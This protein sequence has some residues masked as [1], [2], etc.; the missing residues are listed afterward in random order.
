MR[1]KLTSIGLFMLLLFNVNFLKSQTIDTNAVDGQ[2]Y[3]KIFDHENKVF[4]L[5]DGTN[6][7]GLTEDIKFLIQKFG[8]ASIEKAFPD[9]T[10]NIKISKIY[11]I[12]FTHYN[13][14]YEL[15]SQFSGR[16]Y[17]EYSERVP[18]NKIFC[19][20][21][22]A[23]YPSYWTTQAQS[24]HLNLINACGAWGINTGN[25]GVNVAIVDNEF[26]VLHPDLTNIVQSW[27][28]ADNDNNVAGPNAGFD[29]GTHV[30]GIAGASTNNN[31][32]IASIG[33]N[34]S[35][36]VVKATSD[37]A[38][39]NSIT[40]GYQAITWAMNNG[41]D[42][43]NCSW[44]GT[45]YSAAE[46]TIIDQAINAGIVVVAAAGNDNNNTPH[47][48]AAYNGVYA[49]ANTDLN[50]VK[51][52]SSC[53]GNWVDISAPGTNI[54]SSVYTGG[55]G[56]KTG[57]SMASPLV[58]G[59]CGLI[60]SNNPNYTPQQVTNCISSTAELIGAQ[61]NPVYAGQL[62]TGRINALAAMQCSQT[63]SNFVA[64]SANQTTICANSPITFTDAS[65]TNSPITSW[66]WSFPGSLTPNS[67]SQNP[68]VIYPTG[69]EY[70]V[71]LTITTANGTFTQTY[72]TYVKVLGVII[73]NAVSNSPV[74][75]GAET[76]VNLI[77][78]GSPQYTV[79]YNV[80]NGTTLTSSLN[81]N[82]VPL[83]FNTSNTV[84]NTTLNIVSITANGVTCNSTESFTITTVNCCGELVTNGDFSAGNTSFTTDQILDCS[85][86]CPGEYCVGSYSGPAAVFSGWNIFPTIQDRG[87]SL[88]I[89]GRCNPNSC[90]GNLT[91]FNT[92]GNGN[93]TAQNFASILW[94][95]QATLTANTNYNVSFFTTQGNPPFA[96]NA[97]FAPLHLRFRI[98]DLTNTTIFTSTVFEV[99]STIQQSWQQ[100]YF[101][102][103]NPVTS[104]A[105]YNIIIEQVEF[106]AFGFYDFLMDDISMRVVNDPAASL[107][108]TSNPPSGCA[109]FPSTLNVS[110]SN[111]QESNYTYS[112]TIPPSTIPFSNISNP[113]VNPTV[114]TT[115]SLSVFEST[116]RCTATNT[117]TV[118][119]VPC[120][121]YCAD[122]AAQVIPEGATST[123]NPITNGTLVDIQGT[124]IINTN[125]TLN[126]VKFRMAA[127]SSII[128]NP[129]FTWSVSNSFFFSCTDMWKGI[130]ISNNSATFVCS[131][132]RIEDALS[133]INS[134]SGGKYNIS[135]ST[136]NKNYVGLFVDSYSST[137]S[138]TVK[139][140]LFDCQTSTTSPGAF[141]KSPYLGVRSHYGIDV[142]NNTSSITFGVAGGAGN[143]NEFT[144][145]DVGI[146]SSNSVM[147]SYNNYFHD[148][149]R[150]CVQT[151]GDDPCQYEGWGIVAETFGKLY[152]GDLSGTQTFSNNYSNTFRNCDGGILAKVQVS[153]IFIYKNNFENIG[154]ATIPYPNNK[155]IYVVSNYN[156]IEACLIQNNRF[157]DNYISVQYENNKYPTCR[158]NSNK[159]NNSA[160]YGIYCRQ[161]Y[162]PTTGTHNLEIKYNAMNDSTGASSI[163]GIVAQNSITTNSAR[164]TIEANSIKKIQRAIWVTKF[165]KPVVRFH[166]ANYTTVSG[167]SAGIT[168]PNVVPTAGNPNYGICVENSPSATIIENNVQKQ[169]GNPTTAYVG[170]SYGISSSYSPGSS[171]VNNTVYRMGT[172]LNFFGT[173]N[174]Q[175]AS[176]NLMYNNRVGLAQDNTF[177]GNQGSSTQAQDNQ[178]NIPGGTGWISA[179]NVPIGSS[180]PFFYSRSLS[181]PFMS[182]TTN[183]PMS[184]ANAIQPL[185]T[186]GSPAYS[187]TF[188][189]AS[190]PCINPNIARI[191]KRQAPFEALPLEEQ[192][193]ADFTALQLIKTYDSLT[194]PNE[195]EAPTLL[196]FK[197]SLATTNTG[198]LA[199]FAEKMDS[200]DSLAAKQAL[201]AVAPSYSPEENAKI[202][203]EIYYRTWAKDV[204][205]FNREDSTRLLLVAQQWPLKGGMAVYDARVMIGYWQNDFT[206]YN[207]DEKAARLMN[208]DEEL[209]NKDAFGVLYPNPAQNEVHYD[210]SLSEEETGMLMIYDA[211][212]KLVHAEKIIAGENKLLMNTE[213]WNNGVYLY[214]LLINDQPKASQT[215]IINK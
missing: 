121:Q 200:G 179:S 183:P 95:Q 186:S 153:N 6:T 94:A 102:V 113:T 141:L 124:Y 167:T 169:G 65:V 11:R 63:S 157:R 91:P 195:P 75:K 67:N 203:D 3:V 24:G 211:L 89:D 12:T 199:T 54:L 55:Y 60:L 37:A 27:D 181:L 209:E 126:N 71:T 62:G 191:A 8:I 159:F 190:P 215:F 119:I 2:I 61:N 135:G 9:I 196:A 173:N 48:P 69:G 170:L 97:P 145:I 189:C 29:H 147:K 35:L 163:Y 155:A 28:R 104:N 133:G 150:Y 78:T 152:V 31:T 174:A 146:H 34:I 204:F 41:A 194:M 73:Q 57:T 131:K 184:P 76:Q 30:A 43:I 26:N 58:A 108:I 132:N 96:G 212:G 208:S 128:I 83:Y 56:I 178:W 112:W 44:G 156:N 140:S 19:T 42:V 79:N 21:E 161:N 74:C 32:G 49:V 134:L 16:N 1:N 192:L 127:G 162:N 151:P 201:I 84:A 168:F 47:Y 5:Y 148:L 116:T 77:L 72:Q 197:D 139:S 23:T 80:D 36:I 100:V 166:S 175:T 138:S 177:I 136:F 158:I 22:G 105:T 180:S 7:N 66:A 50:D 154:S 172:G 123:T 25:N 198:L 120:G 114:T 164:L 38:A 101:N 176:C 39:G 52:P 46:Q 106:F 90:G 193:V 130:Y 51:S 92:P 93:V 82:F 4:P 10:N 59:L 213:Q 214:R 64:F 33:R 117:A 99:P 144:N 18:L 88:V 85:S 20:N 160:L 53:F 149:R 165:Q 115:Y 143:Q 188:G 118:T 205:F 109:G 171:V 40:H 110:P 81:H 17:V 45:L 15:M 202:V 206:P 86:G 210:I 87:Q 182:A 125:V 13:E 122:I 70:D 68:V 103:P 187:C 142:L 111:F 185:L 98:T 129:G 207:A 137:N 107:N 14:V